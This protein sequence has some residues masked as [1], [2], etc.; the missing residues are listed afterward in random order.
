MFLRLHSLCNVL[1]SLGRVLAGSLGVLVS[2]LGIS[3]AMQLCSGHMAGSCVL[4]M[5]TSLLV[6][7]LWGRFS[8][9]V[10]CLG[11]ILGHGVLSKLRFAKARASN[12]SHGILRAGPAG[13][14]SA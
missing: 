8:D 12:A 9:G 7:V 3:F 1:G 11:C 4:Q 14:C 13:F 5:F 10:V 6:V 2:G